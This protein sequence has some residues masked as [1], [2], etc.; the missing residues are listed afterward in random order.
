MGT[1]RGVSG[2]PFTP[3]LRPA[4]CTYVGGPEPP[5]PLNSPWRSG[6]PRRSRWRAC[7]PDSP[8]QAGILEVA[9][10]G[11]LPLYSRQTTGRLHPR[12]QV[13]TDR[14]P[15]G[16]PDG[17]TLA[18]TGRPP[19]LASAGRL[20]FRTRTG[21]P[22]RPI[23]GV[24][25]NAL[26]K[27]EDVPPTHPTHPSSRSPTPVTL[28]RNQQRTHAHLELSRASQDNKTSSERGQAGRED[29]FVRYA[30]SNQDPA[31][32]VVYLEG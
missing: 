9:L 32:R 30:N 13:G 21:H 11:R 17:L 5:E 14:T 2:N 16:G 23:K 29:K 31:F 10:A 27:R 28:I 8:G 18:R 19:G 3:A 22:E 6:R 25:R 12:Q 20:G 1:R 24:R 15:L 4:A 7:H 26:Q